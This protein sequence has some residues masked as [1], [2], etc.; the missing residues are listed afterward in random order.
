MP[1]R[2]R[3]HVPNGDGRVGPRRVLPSR[4]LTSRHRVPRPARPGGRI[5]GEIPGRCAEC[6][7]KWRKL[8]LFRRPKAPFFGAPSRLR[9]IATHASARLYV[10]GVRLPHGASDAPFLRWSA[11]FHRPGHETT[12]VRQG[13]F[14]DCADF[15]ARLGRPARSQAVPSLAGFGAALFA[16]MEPAVNAQSRVR[17]G[18]RCSTAG[19][20]PGTLARS[21]SEGSLI[22]RVRVRQAHRGRFGPV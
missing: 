1:R 5:F 8:A 17:E 12:C 10:H 7:G 22:P 18:A 20:A 15:V 21:A 14:D 16:R 13:R 11:I 4:C 19:S 9:S 3:R 2:W 6:Q